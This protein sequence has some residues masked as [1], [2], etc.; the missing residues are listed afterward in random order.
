MLSFCSSVCG[1]AKLFP[2]SWA[3]AIN[4]QRIL[5]VET[6]KEDKRD[7]KCVMT[8]ET[9]E[10]QKNVD[11]NSN[12]KRKQIEPNVDVRHKKKT[13]SHKSQSDDE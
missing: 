5:D 4:A 10:G 1:F 12:F 8:W 3:E 7:A 6:N 11:L 13:F 2:Y 9:P